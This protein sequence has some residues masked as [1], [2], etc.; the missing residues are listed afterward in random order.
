[1]Q[2][3]KCFGN[4]EVEIILAAN[5]SLTLFC[6]RITAGRITLLL[7]PPGAGKSTLLLALAGRLSE[8]LEV[9]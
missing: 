6:I 3:F 1:M 2:D 9:R 5:H 4:G 8:S 7:G